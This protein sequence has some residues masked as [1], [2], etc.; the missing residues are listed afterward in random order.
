MHVLRSSDRPDSLQGMAYQLAQLNIGRAL[1]PL[2]SARL[3]SFV[4]LLE[5]VNALADAAPGFVWRLQTEDGDATS[6][7]PFDDDQIIVNLTVWESVEALTAFVYGAAHAAVL[8]RRREWFSSL[9][10][11]YSVAWWIPAGTIPT[12]A[13]ARQRLDAL[14]SDGPSAYAFTL[15]EPQPAPAQQS[16]G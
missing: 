1:E 5:P 15:K 11:P 4:E 7:R 12:V 14:R 8:R 9:G 16:A 13:Q 6:V 3:A 2:T 10:Q